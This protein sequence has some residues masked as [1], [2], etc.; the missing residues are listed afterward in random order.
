L[1]L[2]RHKEP[3]VARNRKEETAKTKVSSHPKK[4][5]GRG[6]LKPI[7]RKKKLEGVGVFGCGLFW[8]VGGFFFGGGGGFFLG[9][10]CCFWDLKLVK[11]RRK[12]RR[13]GR[14]NVSDWSALRN[15]KGGVYGRGKALT[16]A[17][18]NSRNAH[19][20]SSIKWESP[21]T[22]K[23][24]REKQ[25]M[26]FYKLELSGGEGKR[27]QAEQGERVQVSTR[28]KGGVHGGEV[29]FHFG[30]GKRGADLDRNSRGSPTSSLRGG[31]GRRGET[32]G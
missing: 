12:L 21:S 2:N 9:V 30:W 14:K 32:E 7:V 22:R 6:G 17:K 16:A 1:C 4:G 5:G 23:D 18:E 13:T 19:P 24:R 11:E 8:V 27:R 26:P 3:E 31:G 20:R 15:E 28:G 29:G 25:N 10:G